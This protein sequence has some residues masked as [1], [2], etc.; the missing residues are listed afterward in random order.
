MVGQNRVHIYM[1]VCECVCADI[2]DNIYT[3][4]TSGASNSLMSCLPLYI[5]SSLVL[6]HVHIT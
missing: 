1:Y 2:V 4:P 5:L 6:L 3:C